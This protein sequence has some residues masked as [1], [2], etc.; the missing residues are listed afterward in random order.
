MNEIVSEGG[1]ET[2]VAPII[3][4]INW[5]TGESEDVSNTRCMREKSVGD[6]GEI[7]R[8]CGLIILN[9]Y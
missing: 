8:L 6:C 2:V 3:A 4:D 1:N 5:Q 7:G 9:E